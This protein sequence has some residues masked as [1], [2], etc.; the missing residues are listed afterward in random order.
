MHV[1]SYFCLYL[2]KICVFL[3]KCYNFQETKYGIRVICINQNTAINSVSMLYYIIFF[4]MSEINNIFF[5][6]ILLMLPVSQILLLVSCYF[7]LNLLN[8]DLFLI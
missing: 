2:E 8:I 4:N 6:Y 5:G 7:S 1:S 3:P